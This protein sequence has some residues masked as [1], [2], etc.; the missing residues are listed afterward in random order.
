MESLLCDGHSKYQTLRPGSDLSKQYS[1]SQ[2]LHLM[3]VGNLRCW[4]WLLS[5]ESEELGGFHRIVR[6]GDEEVSS[7]P[8][9]GPLVVDTER[10]VQC[11]GELKESK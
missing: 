2:G 10:V 8:H 5:A 11:R 9:T 1:I 7:M 6:E 3:T 4:C